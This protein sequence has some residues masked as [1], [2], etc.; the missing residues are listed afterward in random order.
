M[1][2]KNAG[3]NSVIAKESKLDFRDIEIS[4]CN[5]NVEAVEKALSDITDIKPK[6][7]DVEKI[8]EDWP[9]SVVLVYERVVSNM[10]QGVIF[11]THALDAGASG[12]RQIRN[13]KC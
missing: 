6:I 5:E 10:F 12:F 4:V 11:G 9:G 13:K 8:S 7:I 3:N 2:V 1:L